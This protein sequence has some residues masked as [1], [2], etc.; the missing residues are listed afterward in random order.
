MLSQYV[1]LKRNWENWLHY[2]RENIPLMFSCYL[3]ALIPVN[4]FDRHVGAPHWD[5]NIA[6]P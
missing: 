4:L 3:L 1:I 5:L 6:V 2:L